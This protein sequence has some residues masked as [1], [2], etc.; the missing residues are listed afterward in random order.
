MPFFFAAPGRRIGAW[1]FT[2]GQTPL[3]PDNGHPLIVV[4]EP[5]LELPWQDRRVQEAQPRTVR[6]Q[7]AD[8]AIDL[9]PPADDRGSP[10]LGGNPWCSPGLRPSNT[11]QRQHHAS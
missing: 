3:L 11:L 1:N 8:R 2:P 6:A 9:G 7:V 10:V 4:V 5:Q